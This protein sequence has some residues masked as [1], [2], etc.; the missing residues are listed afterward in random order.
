ML[1]S[2]IFEC[3]EKSITAKIIEPEGLWASPEW[4]DFIHISWTGKTL[5]LIDDVYLQTYLNKTA[6]PIY[7][8]VNMQSQ[9][10]VGS[11]ML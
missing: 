5:G 10:R 3:V 8:V 11:S 9:V 4:H 1:N 6:V 7:S 2:K